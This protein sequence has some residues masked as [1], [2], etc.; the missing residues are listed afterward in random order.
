MRLE[1]EFKQEAANR[2][3]VLAERSQ[4]VVNAKS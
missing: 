4:K 2:Q 1:F 3:K